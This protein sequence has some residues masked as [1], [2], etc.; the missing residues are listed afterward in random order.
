[1]EELKLTVHRIK[2][3]TETFCIPYNGNVYCVDIY[4]DAEERSAWIYRH[5]SGIKTHMFGEET[6][7]DRD[8]FID[9]VFHNVPDYADDYE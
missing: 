7:N 4:E 5:D 2:A 1:M 6:K 8:E 3:T 9:L